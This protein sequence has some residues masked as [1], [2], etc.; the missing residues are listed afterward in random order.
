ML[1]KCLS[2]IDSDRDK[3]ST[4]P[5]LALMIYFYEQSR[6]AR[7]RGVSEKAEKRKE[8]K[9]RERDVKGGGYVIPGAAMLQT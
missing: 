7:K 9:T 4:V 3:S 1:R 2:N 8:N 5:D 6:C